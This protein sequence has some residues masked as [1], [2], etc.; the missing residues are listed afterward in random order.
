MRRAAVN[1]NAKFALLDDIE[2][3]FHGV[4]R[5]A[6]DLLDMVRGVSSFGLT[7]LSVSDFQLYDFELVNYLQSQLILTR[8]KKG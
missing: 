8:P 6:F 2:P 7:P 4:I 3:Q 5:Y 1:V